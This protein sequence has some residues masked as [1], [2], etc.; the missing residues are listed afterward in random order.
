MDV[1]LDSVFYC[2]VPNFWTITSKQN[3]Y[4]QSPF[5]SSHFKFKVPCDLLQSHRK[6]IFKFCF[7]FCA[8]GILQWLPFHFSVSKF[9]FSCA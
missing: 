8:G 6:A 2:V 7:K 1:R 3:T 5:N 4:L 9:P